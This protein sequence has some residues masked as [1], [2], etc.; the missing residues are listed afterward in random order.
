MNI[1]IVKLSAIGDVIHTLPSLAALRRL[2]PD[3][4][5]TW[6][7]E[8]AAA[9]LV[10][11]HPLLNTVLISRRKSWIK[12]FS[13]GEIRRPLREIR[14]FLR[15]LRARPYDLVIDFHGL[16]KS[17]LIVLLSGGKRK[18]G[19]DSLQELSGLFYTE[20]IPEDMS[21]HA[22]DRYLDFLRYLGVQTAIPEFPLPSDNTA[23]AKVQATLEKHGL[24]NKKF[25]AVNPVAYWET[26]LWDNAKFARLADAIKTRLNVE[27]VFTG[28]E[29]DAIEKIITQMSTKTVNLVGETTLSELAYLYKKAQLVLTTDSGPMHLAAAVGTEVVALFGPTDAKRTGPYGE[30]HK[31]IRT[32]LPCSPCFLKKCPTIKCMQDISP[33]QVMTLIEER[34]K[35]EKDGNQ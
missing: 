3:A 4:H 25:I 30:G 33:E 15:K 17:A 9:G 16:L 19:Y 7:V 32:D 6:V 26:K 27:V 23:E 22:V 10:R 28:S 14:S 13:N 1:L 12:D 2:Y 8:E 29:K 5:I 31:I 34:L 11:N 20:R 35:G 18:L 21:K 24:I